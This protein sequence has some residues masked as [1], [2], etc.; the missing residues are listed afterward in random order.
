MI[1]TLMETPTLSSV[2]EKAWKEENHQLF[3]LLKASR[4]KYPD[5]RAF[6]D[7]GRLYLASSMVNRS[8]TLG[9]RVCAAQDFSIPTVAPYYAW[10]YEY[11]KELRHTIYADPPR[12]EVACR[13]PS[14][15][16]AIPWPGLDLSDY[17]ITPRAIEAVNDWLR[18]NT[19]VNIED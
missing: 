5:L 16:G 9:V 11:D 17:N 14:G 19:P 13:N 7:N 18:K 1:V 15:F 8:L 6:M 4:K 12:I 10:F 2:F 3:F